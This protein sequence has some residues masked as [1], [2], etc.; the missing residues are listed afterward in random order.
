M[1]ERSKVIV[2]AV[3]LVVMTSLATLG[4]TLIA[5]G[6][7]L[8]RR[9]VPPPGQ[10][11]TG[12]EPDL[13]EFREVY[14]VLRA[15]Y[16][17][18]LPEKD[19]IA[20][21]IDGMIKATKDPHT[22]YFNAQEFQS[23]LQQFEEHFSGIGVY[24]EP[25]GEYITV[26]APIKG[27]P[28]EKAGLAAG[29][30]IVKVNGQD[31]VGKTADEV[32]NLIRGPE[33]TSV[34]VT[35]ERGDPPQN[36]EFKIKRARIQIPSVEARML[37][38]GIGYIQIIQFNENVSQRIRDTIGDLNKQGLKGLV[39]DL[40][41]NPG[42]QLD[43]AIKVAEIFVP[44]GPVVSVVDRQ[45]NREDYSSNSKGLGIPYVVLVDEGS[46][47]ASEIVA[48]AIQDRKTAPLIGVKTFG[49]GSVQNIIDLNGGSGLKVTTA[50]YLTPNGRSI[51]GQGITPDVIVETPKTAE[52]VATVPLDHVENPQL[53]KA[54]EVLRQKLS[55]R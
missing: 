6:E 25:K 47:S 27:T 3:L 35:V 22:A 12:A 49:K 16:V 38:P 26:V 23:F 28:G 53:I 4:I 44:Q 37:E 20:G 8:T 51:H 36:L 54:L 48:G 34:E 2:G 11:N 32:A 14:G 17:D 19:L 30:K 40:R 7:F 24:I 46:A 33:G 45:G 43:E 10:T 50:K 9:P 42:G 15:K 31:V 52:G 13:S 55:S 29:D 41:H 39:V 1:I 5:D 18:E 21:A